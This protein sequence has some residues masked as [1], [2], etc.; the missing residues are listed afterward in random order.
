VIDEKA[1]PCLKKHRAPRPTETAVAPE[2]A[3][4]E[5]MPER[6]LLGIFGG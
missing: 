4:R 2:A 3:L 6:T 1:R 5:R